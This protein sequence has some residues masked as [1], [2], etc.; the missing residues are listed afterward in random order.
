MNK[1]KILTVFGLFAFSFR[2]LLADGEA[3]TKQQRESFFG[4]RKPKTASEKKVQKIEDVI[5]NYINN[6]SDIKTEQVKTAIIS[7]VKGLYP[8]SGG[9]DGKPLNINITEI[10]KTAE[11]EAQ[12]KF[13]LTDKDLNERYAK[14]ADE[15]YKPVQIDSV[16][17]VNYKQGPYTNSITGRYFGLTYYND[18]VRIENSVVPIFDLSDIDKGKFDEKVRVIK[19]KEYISSKLAAYAEQKKGVTDKTIKEKINDIVKQNEDNGYIFIW[20]K[21][22]TPEKVVNVLITHIVDSLN[23]K[24][25]EPNFELKKQKPEE[26]NSEDISE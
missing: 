6:G 23:K 20:N 3:P 14:E 25:P 26:N 24:T 1:I 10:R 4:N 17:T 7:D 15:I 8:L 19:K 2:I 16:I 13:S 21:W 11:V 18:G 5:Y 9:D 12:K 22:L